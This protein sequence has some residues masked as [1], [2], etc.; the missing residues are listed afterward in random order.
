LP[1]FLVDGVRF[2][3]INGFELYFD[4]AF[5]EV[6]K[7]NIDVVLCPSASSFDSSQRWSELLKTRA[8]LNS[9][10]ILRANRVGVYRDKISQWDFYGHSSL[11]TPMGDIEMTLGNKEEILITEINKDDLTHARKTWGWKKSLSKREI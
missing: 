3:I 7:K 5:S 10:Y 6:M 2:G 4:N 8:L 1:T 9:V 11:V